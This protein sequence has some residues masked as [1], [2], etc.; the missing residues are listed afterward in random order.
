MITLVFLV[1]VLVLVFDFACEI[2]YQVLRLLASSEAAV[3]F[4]DFVFMKLVLYV[5]L[6]R[7]Y[8]E[9]INLSSAL[10]SY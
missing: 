3:L 2:I 5:K 7:H 6:Q 8:N 4:S 10:F 1:L 9:I